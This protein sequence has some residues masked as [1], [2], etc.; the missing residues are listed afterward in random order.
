MLVTLALVSCDSPKNIPPGATAG[1]L[2]LSN[3]DLEK[4]GVVS[5][6]GEYEFYWQQHLNPEDFR[7]PGHPEKTGFIRV[8]GS[9][10]GLTIGGHTL[11]GTGYATYRLT[12]MLTGTSSVLALKFLDMGT[13]YTVFADGVR[14][15]AVG[16]AGTTPELTAP[17]YAP[18]VVDVVPT[19]RRLELIYQ[20][21]NFHHRRGGA[22]EVIQL[23]TPAQIH[24]IRGRRLEFD[25][26]L[27]GSLIIM[28]LYHIALFPHR[29]RRDLSPVYFGLFCIIVAVRILITV[30]RYALHLLPRLDWEWFVAVEYLTS[31]LTVPALALFI[32]HLFTEEFHRI[33]LRGTIAVSL[34]SAGV[35]L[36]TPARVY[37]HFATFYQLFM[38]SC[39]VYGIYV[40]VR[41]V[42]RHR[43][44]ARVILVGCIILTGTVINDV[45][46]IEEVFY[47]SHFAHVGLFVFT[48]SYAI[49]LSFRYSRAFMTVDLQRDGLVRANLLY[50]QELAEHQL[51]EKAKQELQEKL[52]MA[53]KMEA[54]GVL[55]GG[56]AHDL[57]NILAGLVGYPDLLLLD[58]PADSPLRKPLENIM[59]SG[60]RA[61]AVVEDLLT[62][63]RR[64]AMQYEAVNLND[65]VAGCL[66]S[67]DYRRLALDHPRV[68][69]DVQ[70]AFALSCIKGSPVHLRRALV[71]LLSNAFEAQPQGGHVIVS[72]FDRCVDIGVN[73]RGGIP[74]GTYAAL[75]VEDTG[76]SI[77]PEDL[78]RIFEPFYTKKVLGK[79]GT[80]LG[81][82][83]VLGVVQD[84]HGHIDVRSVEGKGSTF[85]LFFPVTAEEVCRTARAVPVG[86]Y[87]G[88]HESI[89]VVDDAREQRELALRILSTLGY[90][91][92]T[93]SSGEEAVE[94]VK[95]HHVDLMVLDMIMDPGIDG[96]ET[97]QSVI[98]LHPE[99]K[100][101]V[102][103]GYAETERV[104]MTLQL[105]AGRV[106]RKPYTVETLGLAVRKELDAR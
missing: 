2:D 69:V 65:V 1:V 48:L 29:N 11:T 75:R 73:D 64:G 67:P 91:V 17:G 32:Y 38:V 21:S 99:M 68:S 66:S 76:E 28:G 74:A 84:H 44:G 49:L 50:E 90:S 58:L 56:V 37:S 30:E 4:R 54:I 93:A 61:A 96:L 31:A 10:N 77:S 105:G 18:Q 40:M 33:V 16:N 8:P 86:E 46:D 51:A 25:L 62:L 39:F 98:K 57:N 102:A 95:H 24:D 9:W 100:A 88:H 94:Y 27:F 72:T 23:G 45:L 83:V 41:A 12:V 71:N 82:S 13:A 34:A 14:I 52:V 92:S 103:S 78:R 42:R 36:V 59:A 47:T 5:L 70:L 7:S 101:V 22:W 35:V 60:K 53:Q 15:L 81:L 97:Y 19:S 63:A 80:G 26:I 43:E 3:W 89:L 20:V 106:V 55:A 6:S 104:R 85:E 79:S 87:Q